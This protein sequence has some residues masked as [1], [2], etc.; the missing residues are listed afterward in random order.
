MNNSQIEFD[1]EKPVDIK[2]VLRQ[3]Q[4][5]LIKV[6]EAVRAVNSTPQW[7]TLKGLI[8]DKAVESLQR[9]LQVESEKSELNVQEIYRLQGQ[10][11]WARRYSDFSKLADAY[12]IELNNITKK[13]NDNGTI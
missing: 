4:A 1:E 5:E 11:V 3:K 6:I 9:R 7:Q 13:L 10:L 2:P 8:F 12:K